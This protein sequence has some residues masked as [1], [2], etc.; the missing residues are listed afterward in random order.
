M[1]TDNMVCPNCGI[2]QPTARK[3]TKCGIIV[4][5]WEGRERR[6]TMSGGDGKEEGHDTTQ[7]RA[8]TLYIPDFR[9]DG[10]VVMPVTGYRGRL[11]DYLNQKETTFVAIIK[12]R[13]S[14]IEG[15]TIIPFTE[16]VLVN[17][18]QI[19]LALPT[20]EVI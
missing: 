3:C 16:V 4:D 15:K 5:K 9:I 14:T 19:S 13:I 1:A 12:A 20:K 17:K 2:E 18:N 8:I 11:S 6:E 7:K 10:Y